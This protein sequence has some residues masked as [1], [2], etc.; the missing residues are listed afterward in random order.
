MGR[1]IIFPLPDLGTLYFLRHLWA[2]YFCGVCFL[3]L[4]FSFVFLEGGCGCFVF[5]SKKISKK[6]CK[7]ISSV[8][9]YFYIVGQ[10]I[11]VSAA[12]VLVN[13]E[14]KGV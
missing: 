13:G 8:L 14:L 1:V 9:A 12:F 11:L 2:F 10:C 3:L 4:L 6:N 5:L 7:W